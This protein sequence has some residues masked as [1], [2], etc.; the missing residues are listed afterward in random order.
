MI[1]KGCNRLA[2]V[3]FSIAVDSKHALRKNSMRHGLPSTLH[4][5]RARRPLA[6]CRSAPLGLLL[7][8]RCDP[9]CPQKFK[10]RAGRTFLGLPGWNSAKR[11]QELK[12]DLCLRRGLPD[13]VG[14]VSK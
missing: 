1:P 10:A 9:R 3:V 8:E 6:A 13:D 12:S 11:Q 2:L 7:P 14:N 4:F 5:E